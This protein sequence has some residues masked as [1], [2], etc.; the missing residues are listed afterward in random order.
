MLN[1]QTSGLKRRGS[2]LETGRAHFSL[3]VL[4]SLGTAFI[5]QK[6]LHRYGR[7]KLDVFFS[8]SPEPVLPLFHWGNGCLFTAHFGLNLGSPRPFS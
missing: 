6:I 5:W 2:R 3:Y 4:H 1:G 7:F 8:Q